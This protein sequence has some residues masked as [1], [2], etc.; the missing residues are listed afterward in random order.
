MKIR[1]VT[2]KSCKEVL[3]VIAFLKCKNLVSEDY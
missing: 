1:I 2:E 3:P